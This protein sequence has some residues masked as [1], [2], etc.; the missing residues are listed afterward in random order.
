MKKI[1]VIGESCRDIFIYCES[2][3]LAPDVPV[4]VLNVCKQVENGGMAKNVHLNVLSIYP[5]CDIL[6]NSNWSNITKTRYMHSR[7]NHAFFRVDSSDDIDRINLEKISYDYELVVI[8]DYDKG[9]LSES[10]I[11]HI[12]SSHNLVFL[13]TKKI[14][15]PWANKAFVIKINEYEYNR[16]KPFIN[17]ILYDRIIH[18]H[19]AEG[20]VHRGIK[21]PVNKVD[22]KDTS[23]AGD[24][25]MAGLAVKYLQTK[26]LE[27]SIQFANK[28]ASEIVKRKGVAII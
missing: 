2:N 3:R 7:S 24:T 17:D 19:G 22:V 27:K 26:S 25:F 20:C 6:T 16:S 11:E 9:L 21:Y 15:G 28:C 8:S 13:D 14:L 10:D 18:T 23:G 1:L 4:P 12:C 5:Q